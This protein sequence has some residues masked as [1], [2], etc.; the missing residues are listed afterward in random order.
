GRLSS[1]SG[2]PSRARTSHQGSSRAS[3][4]W[5]ARRLSRGSGVPTRQRPR[6][7]ER[8]QGTLELSPSATL[9]IGCRP[10]ELNAQLERLLSCISH[11]KVRT[12]RTGPWLRTVGQVTG[13]DEREA[14]RPHGPEHEDGTRGERDDA[15]DGEGGGDRCRK[16]KAGPR[17]SRCG[18]LRAD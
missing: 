1:R 11:F 14:D 7:R 8:V 12:A 4:C 5:G 15:G 16:G 2:S 9:E 10:W 3:N 17:L 18:P 6:P 13:G